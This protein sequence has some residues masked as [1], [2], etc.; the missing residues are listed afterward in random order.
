[1][2]G[3]WW[4]VGEWWVLI[5]AF[6]AGLCRPVACAGQWHLSSHPWPVGAHCVCPPCCAACRAVVAVPPTLCR[7][8][9]APPAP[10][11]PPTDPSIFFGAS[12]CSG[13]H[14]DLLLQH[15]SAGSSQHQQAGRVSRGG[16]R[17]GSSG[18]RQSVKLCS[19]TQFM[20]QPDQYV[21]QRLP[22]SGSQDSGAP[23]GLTTLSRGKQRLIHWPGPQA[24]LPQGL[25]P[26]ALQPARHAVFPAP[27]CRPAA[28]VGPAAA[29]AER[30]LCG[31][32]SSQDNSSSLSKPLPRPHSGPRF[33]PHCPHR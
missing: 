3:E 30:L 14:S 5:C 12:S 21:P 27:A 32:A 20:S 25:C 2:L 17:G 33:C 22:D 4:V 10:D 1:M 6:V 26:A 13:A 9:P 18:S 19:R 29:A 8:P 11:S 24:A 23:L 31:T 7:E 28:E 15:T 16:S